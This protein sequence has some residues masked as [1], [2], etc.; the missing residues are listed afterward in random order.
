MS[1]AVRPVC[2]ADEERKFLTFPW[3]IYQNDPLWVP[4]LL[5]ERRKFLFQQQAPFFRRGGE[6]QAF[7]AWQ[8]RQVVGT[9]VAGN[10][11]SL[12]AQRGTKDCVI[13]F[14]E[15]IADPEVAQALFDTAAAWGKQRGLQTLYG[16]FNLD[17]EDA[18][19]VLVEGR[20][21]P[22][23]ILCGHTPP[24]YLEFFQNAGFYTIRG[25]G[26]A[27]AID[28]DPGL[29][30][31]SRL[32][33]LAG[34]LRQRTEIRVRGGDLAHIDEEIERVYLLINRALAHLSDFI[35][36]QR[37]AL[38]E[39]FYSMRRIADPELVLFA[40]LD[41]KVIGWFPGIPNLNE[42]L[43]H[44]NGLR[45]PWDYLR[46]LFASR[47]RPQC[48]AIKSVL[49]D[50]DYWDT[51]VAVLLFDEMARRARA[52]GYRW[53]DMSITSEDNPD[54]PILA[55]HAG[56]YIYKRYRIFRRQIL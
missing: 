23:A 30:I 15:C 12:N 22:P 6:A 36:W 33:R 25:D 39:L 53:A 45:Y 1:L 50:P 44:A 2:N 56:A 43:I 35:P 17:Y 19:G 10:D 37:A 29:P 8:G 9:I 27:Y 13:G 4:P 52:K 24:Y 48:L 32:N 14:F 11:I 34:R 31:M 16:P 49:V 7:L 28:L 5:P 47:R 18:Y 38:Q 20:D 42:I 46:L 21:R 54:T 26:L 41:G 40:E 55:R 51:G 3:K